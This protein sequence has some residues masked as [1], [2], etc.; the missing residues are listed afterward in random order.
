MSAVF[1]STRGEFA[2]NSREVKDSGKGA[3]T[4]NRFPH[5]PLKL[6]EI[7]D[8]FFASSL[9]M[10]TLATAT[11]Y[12]SAVPVLFNTRAI[13]ITDLWNGAGVKPSP[14]Y[15]IEAQDGL[16]FHA[17]KIVNITGLGDPH[18]PVKDPASRELILKSF[19]QTNR[20]G[21]L[22]GRITNSDD[23]LSIVGNRKRLGLTFVTESKAKTYVVIAPGDGGKIAVEKLLSPDFSPDL[24]IVWIAQKS[25][26]PEAFR[27]AT[28]F[29]YHG[30][31]EEIGKRIETIPDYATR[32]VPLPDGRIQVFAD[33]IAQS[34]IGD[35]V[36][37]A[38]GYKNNFSSL[39]RDVI[40]ASSVT[41][42]NVTSKVREIGD[43]TNVGTRLKIENAPEQDIYA[44]GVAAVPLA[45]EAEL[46]KSI[47]QNPVSIENLG[48][49]T[50]A[51]AKAL[52]T[53]T[54]SEMVLKQGHQLVSVSLDAIGS[55]NRNRIAISRLRSRIE[56][57]RLLRKYDLQAKQFTL[58]VNEQKLTVEGLTEESARKLLAD[59]QSDLGLLH[60]LA[61]A[62][63]GGELRLTVPAAEGRA[64][65]ENIAY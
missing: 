9:G 8:D 50:S 6:S 42:E 29:R 3:I 7:S 64:D 30:I 27:E 14:R 18:V 32:F 61:T 39:L 60:T 11:Q 46:N 12:A 43:V 35:H 36:I 57:S 2:I 55:A 48:P 38:T 44:G 56:V 52:V 65:V 63:R 33:G 22:L 17:N 53:G 13:K 51:L 5:S 10:S 47:T 15:K 21:T 23:F 59:L 1:W 31:S 19:A 16:I 54:H 20:E 49:R 45:S 41:A 58:R 24:K 62:A 28:F 40:G 25:V 4:T 26:T 34:A 37:L